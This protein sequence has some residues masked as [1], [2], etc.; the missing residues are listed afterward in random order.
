MYF[1]IGFKRAHCFVLIVSIHGIHIDFGIAVS[2]LVQWFSYLVPWQLVCINCHCRSG[3]GQVSPRKVKASPPRSSL[4][5]LVRTDLASVLRLGSSDPEGF[6]P[7]ILYAG[8][9]ALD[10]DNTK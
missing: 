4:V 7:S 6:P 1:Y 8:L 5:A 10:G 3:S 2:R 9:R